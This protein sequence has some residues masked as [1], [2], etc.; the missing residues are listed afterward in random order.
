MNIRII[1]TCTCIT[2]VIAI[3]A[4]LNLRNSRTEV[5]VKLATLDNRDLILAI[6]ENLSSVDTIPDGK[7]LE[8]LRRTVPPDPESLRL[9]TPKSENIIALW[10]LGEIDSVLRIADERLVRDPDDFVGLMIGLEYNMFL[11]DTG[12]PDFRKLLETIYRLSGV[13][14]EIE[15]PELQTATSFIALNLVKLTELSEMKLEAIAVGAYAPRKRDYQ[16]PFYQIDFLRAAERD[17]LF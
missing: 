1:T 3:I 11:F 10:N 8:S 14:T 13:I 15:T 16:R 7:W 5:D 12:Q 6:R 17:G 9:Q 2:V 4:A